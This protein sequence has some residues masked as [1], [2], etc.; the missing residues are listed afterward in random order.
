MDT[1]A[2]RSLSSFRKNPDEPV[3]REGLDGDAKRGGFVPLFNGK[4]LAGWTFPTGNRAD[5]AVNGGILKGFSTR[6]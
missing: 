2:D 1:R 6:H 5:W 4:D 3:K